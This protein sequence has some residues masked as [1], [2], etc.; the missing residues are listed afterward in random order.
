MKAIIFLIIVFFTGFSCEESV[1]VTD[2]ATIGSYSIELIQKENKAFLVTKS[3][4]TAKEHALILKP[5]CYFLREGG[6]V[7]T[8]G[9][10]DVEVDHVIIIIG[11]IASSEEKEM[12]KADTSKVCGKTIQGLLMKKDSAILSEKIIS[13]AMSCKDNGLD[14]KDFWDFAH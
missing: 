6:K 10:S 1:F 3:K 5:P 8:F 4:G 13:G 14:E 7:Q 2:S 12:Y 11:D 9:Y